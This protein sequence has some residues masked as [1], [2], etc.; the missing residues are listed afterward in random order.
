[1]DHG[2]GEFAEIY[3][4]AQVAVGAEAVALKS[5]FFFN[6]GGEVDGQEPRSLI[7]ADTPQ[8][9]VSVD[10]WQLQIEE[11]KLRQF[12]TAANGRGAEEGA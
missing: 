8:H 9:L 10:F 1:L 2:L 7:A 5:V 3:G 12:A 4:L 6:R 11:D